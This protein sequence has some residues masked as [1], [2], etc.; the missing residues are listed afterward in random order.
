LKLDHT[1]IEAQTTLAFIDFYYNWNWTAAEAQL[2]DVLARRS[3]YTIARQWYAEYL[4]AM[5]K[6]DE[7]IIEIH[8]AQEL[9]P[10]SPLLKMM[11]AYIYFYAGR[12][13]QTIEACRRALPLDPGF[14]LVHVYLGGAYSQKNAHAEAEEELR[15]ADELSGG[16]ERYLVAWACARSGKRAEAIRILTRASGVPVGAPQPKASDFALVYA[17]LGDTDQAMIWLEK[18]YQER[19]YQL[20]RAKVDPRLNPLRSDPRFQALLDKM[21]FPK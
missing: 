1:C 7:A 4:C 8:R 5:G 18:A 20:V 2:K 19:E 6:T 21:K 15:K 10:L 13:D 16:G 14:M 3:D 11:E 9:D 17:A 12:Y